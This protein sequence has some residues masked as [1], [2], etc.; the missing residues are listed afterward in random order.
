MLK[1][2]CPIT[3]FCTGTISDPYRFTG[4]LIA[5]V[6]GFIGM[7]VA[8]PSLGGEKAIAWREAAR[9]ISQTAYFIAKDVAEIP[10]CHGIEGDT[11]HASLA[12]GHIVWITI[13]DSKRRVGSNTANQ[14]QTAAVDHLHVL[15]PALT[16][17]YRTKI[18]TWRI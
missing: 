17:D 12:G 16:D 3:A 8:I 7:M 18:K 2:F 11:Y 13:E 6:T 15:S 10:R 14:V 5:W 4:Q 9:G 1:L